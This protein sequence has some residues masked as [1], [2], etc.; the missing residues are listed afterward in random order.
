[1]RSAALVDYLVISKAAVGLL[2]CAS[3][4]C[5]EILNHLGKVRRNLRSVARDAI[6]ETVWCARG[7]IVI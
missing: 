4:S 2:V 5:Q 7:A 1:M 3:Y 6:W